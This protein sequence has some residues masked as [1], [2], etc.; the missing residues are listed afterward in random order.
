MT[1][2]DRVGLNCSEWLDADAFWQSYHNLLLQRPYS[3]PPIGQW[4]IVDELRQQIL[5]L[6][7]LDPDELRRVT[8]AAQ[9][10]RD[11]RDETAAIKEGAG[12]R[13]KV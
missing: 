4:P 7:V 13:D 11:R 8:A 2:A 9:A 3:G 10:E 5:E 12:A 6:V 1:V